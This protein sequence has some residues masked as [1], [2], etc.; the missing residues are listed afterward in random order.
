MSSNEINKVKCADILYF[1]KLS[2]K[3]KIVIYIDNIL[4]LT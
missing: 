1:Q 4:T 3:N 2:Y